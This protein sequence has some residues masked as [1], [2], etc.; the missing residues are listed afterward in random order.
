M[1]VFAD[2]LEPGED[3]VQGTLLIDGESQEDACDALVE[4]AYDGLESLLTGL[5][6]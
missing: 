5:S 2:L 3:G 1:S 4:C 6:K